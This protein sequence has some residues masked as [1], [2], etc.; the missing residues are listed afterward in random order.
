MA[1]EQ[2][3]LPRSQ[4]SGLLQERRFAQVRIPNGHLLG[5][6][7]G[8]NLNWSPSRGFRSDGTS[9]DGIK[10]T[11]YKLTT[12]KGQHRTAGILKMSSGQSAEQLE[13]L[14]FILKKLAMISDSSADT[15]TKAKQLLSNIKN[16]MW[17]GADSHKHFNELLG[18]YRAEILP[19]VID[20]WEDLSA[21]VQQNISAMNYMYCQLHALVG[22]ATYADEAM[23]SLEWFWRQRLG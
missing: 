17:D 13:G 12:G 23:M 8:L 5:L 7:T 18:E 4:L 21:E 22:C 20:G 6:K 14:Q 1:A 3:R 16:T 11:G 2:R 15:I 9:K 19:D 10:C